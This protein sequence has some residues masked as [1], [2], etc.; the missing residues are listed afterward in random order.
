[1]G[2]LTGPAQAA[3]QQDWDECSGNDVTRSIPACSR[4]I[5]D[6][7]EN[8]QN[9]VD[10]FLFRAG[11]HLSQ[12]DFDQAIADYAEAITL[13][14]R[15]AVAYL[16]RAVA[17]FH[18]GDRDRAI[19]DYSIADKIDS[20]NVARIAATN[21]EIEDIGASARA[22]PPSPSALAFVDQLPQIGSPPAPAGT[23]SLTPQQAACGQAM[24]TCVDGCN[25]NANAK[26]TNGSNLAQAM[27]ALD[28]MNCVTKFCQ[29]FG[30]ACESGAITPAQLAKASNP[31]E[32]SDLPASINANLP[33]AAES[34][35]SAPSNRN[36]PTRTQPQKHQHASLGRCVYPPCLGHCNIIEWCIWFRARCPPTNSV[37][38]ACRLDGH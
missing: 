23:V 24:Q 4:I 22:S 11:A 28:A 36:S 5:G 14:P 6:L 20:N 10:G 32:R 34:N 26:S 3:S 9:R 2:V 1:M 13:T 15:N 35:V 7:N 21:K 31:Q 30:G 18:K 12:G 33:P 17:Y 37:V 8:T 16:G 19:L 27:I 38:I 29:P 25:S